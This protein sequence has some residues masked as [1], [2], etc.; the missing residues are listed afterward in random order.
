[1]SV[2]SHVIIRTKQSLATSHSRRPRN[3]ASFYINQRTAARLTSTTI[4]YGLRISHLFRNHKKLE[5]Q[6]SAPSFW[7]IDSFQSLKRE[8]LRLA[9]D[10]E[11]YWSV[12]H[13]HSR[14]IQLMMP[15][16]GDEKSSKRWR[17]I[18]WTAADG[19][20]RHSSHFLSVLISNT[21]TLKSRGAAAANWLKLFKWIEFGPTPRKAYT[22]QQKNFLECSWCYMMG[23]IAKMESV[24]C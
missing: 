18:F 24:F 19:R 6:V 13:S 20:Y 14:W 2:S 8:Q 9:M 12:I 3:H 11:V 21:Q 23:K 5:V 16:H 7:M 15:T 1:M 4:A 17:E 10:G 22:T